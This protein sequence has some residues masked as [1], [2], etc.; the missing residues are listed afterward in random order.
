MLILNM[1]LPDQGLIPQQFHVQERLVDA[2]MNPRL[3][4]MFQRGDEADLIW[5]QKTIN[6]NQ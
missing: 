1:Q 2:A 3:P 4:T 5:M 6:T